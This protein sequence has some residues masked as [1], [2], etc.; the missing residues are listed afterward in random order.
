MPQEQLPFIR[1][2][3]ERL[4]QL[5]RAWEGRGRSVL[6]SNF[7]GFGITCLQFAR[8]QERFARKRHFTDAETTY[9][10]FFQRERSILIAISDDWGLPRESGGDQP[11]RIALSFRQ[12]DISMIG[13]MLQR[14]AGEKHKA[15]FRYPRPQKNVAAKD[16]WNRLL[17]QG[18][19]YQ[20]AKADMVDTKVEEIVPLT[21]YE[22]FEGQPE[23]LWSHWPTARPGPTRSVG[24]SDI[25]PYG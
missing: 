6:V 14:L 12:A 5:K 18:I 7:L 23:S 8:R 17:V 16:L 22:P 25:P 2:Q 21:V 20:G 11:A 19:T 24:G 10:T 13:L 9:P 4:L 1:V 15:P 3:A